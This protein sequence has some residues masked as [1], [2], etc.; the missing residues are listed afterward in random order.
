MQELTNLYKS[1]NVFD[2]MED[3]VRIRNQNGTVLFENK[4]MKSLIQE[5][6]RDGKSNYNIVRL[7]YNLSNPTTLNK[8]TIKRDIEIQDKIYSVKVSPVFEKDEIIGYIE[9][10]RDVT[11]ETRISEELFNAH[12]KINDDIILARTIQKSILPRRLNF[13]NI[14]F[15]Y[16]H[17]PSDNLSGDIFD[18]VEID[19]D[20]IG[21]YIADVVGHGISASIMTMFIRQTMKNILIEFPNIQPSDTLNELKRRFSMLMLDESQY[22][23]IVYMLID[24]KKEK[25]TYVNAGHNCMPL[26]FNDHKVAFMRNRGLFISSI[27]PEVKYNEKSIDLHAGNKILLYTDG[28]LE[29]TDRNGVRFGEE[30]LKK[31]IIK[32]SNNLRLVT[33]LQKHLNTYRWLE[34]KDD[35]AM[36]F[37]DIRAK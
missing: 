12:K 8:S 5:L 7:F 28:L 37:M 26:L 31:W 24:T 13:K 22:F 25:L 6:Y 32:N 10:F 2:S 23:T 18:V 30:S 16:G 1:F 20:R 36:L 34:Q 15:Q 29:T 21:V 35:V 14:H 4:A 33:S 17:I 9:V 11:T 3:L 27:F 19:E